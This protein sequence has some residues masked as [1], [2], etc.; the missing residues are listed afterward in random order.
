MTT[1]LVTS[2]YSC[3]S[4]ENQD[5]GCRDPPH[6]RRNT[7]YPQKLAL[8]SPTSGGC[9]VEIVRSW[10]DEATEF[11]FFGGG[12]EGES[13][14]RYTDD[15]VNGEERLQRGEW[16]FWCFFCRAELWDRLESGHLP[17]R[18]MPVSF[19]VL[20][21]SER[22]IPLWEL[23][24]CWRFRALYKTL[25]ASKQEF[26]QGFI[27]NFPFT[28]TALSPAR[29]TQVSDRVLVTNHC[30]EIKYWLWNNKKWKGILFMCSTLNI[31]FWNNSMNTIFLSLGKWDASCCAII[32]S[33]K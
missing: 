10:T 25:W 29:P 5:F 16:M 22:R 27:F 17:A 4:L 2:L 13:I 20:S 30:R 3:S 21:L 8:I 12:R 33:K 19:L 6:W 1:F 11:F 7:R 15:W 31:C 18:N 26:L 32:M 9:P 28:K 24:S 23:L 14:N